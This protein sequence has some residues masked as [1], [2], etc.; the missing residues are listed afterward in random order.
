MFIRGVPIISPLVSSEVCFKAAASH[1]TNST[2]RAKS[3]DRRLYTV[4][5][6]ARTKSGYR[7]DDVSLGSVAV[8][9]T[10][11]KIN[12]CR[13]LERLASLRAEFRIYRSYTKRGEKP[14]P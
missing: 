13:I 10:A 1:R 2:S 5:S 4:R 3:R 7:R 11:T 8:R 14:Y 6:S 9:P 12:P